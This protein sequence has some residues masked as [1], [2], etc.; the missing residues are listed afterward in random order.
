MDDE[1]RRGIPL[2]AVGDLMV[3]D[4]AISVGYGFASRY[5]ETMETVARQ[6]RPLFGNARFVLGNLECA[7]SRHG[8]VPGDWRSSQMRGWPAYAGDLKEAGFTHLSLANNHS[9]QHGEAPFQET[10]ELLE[11]V[12]IRVC[13]L[14]GTD[15]WAAKP[16]MEEADG[17]TLGI[18]GY[19]L[20][21]RQFSPETPPYAEG[22]EERILD[23]VGRLRGEVDRVMVS[24]HWGGEYTAQPSAAE[25][26]FGHSLVDAGVSV[27]LGHHPHVL[28]PVERYQEGVI[29][30]S[31]GNFLSNMVWER[32]FRR[33]GVLSCDLADPGGSVGFSPAFINQDYVP[34]MT[35]EGGRLDP[36]EEVH[37][38]THEAYQRQVQ[39]AEIQ[40]QFWSYLHAFKNLTA[41][42]RRILFQ[43]VGNTVRNRMKGL[44]GNR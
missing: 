7:L 18:L 14:R 44:L 31:L 41:Y 3:G 11:D 42:D 21:P 37:G 33:T 35:G 8:L 29:A 1:T 30:Y 17:S 24:L 28:R 9:T 25:V 43:L 2:A 23:D 16:V 12:G 34:S 15:G 38:S 36:V 26:R 4:S 39:R 22:P 13:G 20:R 10:V 32:K 19:S 6:V 40:Q 27:V 5:P